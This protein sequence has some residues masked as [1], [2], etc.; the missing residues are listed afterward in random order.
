VRFRE[1][2]YL[3]GF[4][5]NGVFWLYETAFDGSTYVAAQLV[6]KHV[7]SIDSSTEW[8]TN[9]R[10]ACAGEECAL[11]PRLFHAD[12][13]P[14]GDFGTPIDD[15]SFRSQWPRYYEI[16]WE[17]PEARLADLYLIDGRFRVACFVKTLLHC[18]PDALIMI[19]DFANRPQYHVVRKVARE[20]AS[21][22]SLSVFLRK[23]DKNVEHL[24][25][26][27]DAYRFDPE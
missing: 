1:G 17:A 5:L 26:I 15:P 2:A 22:E 14:I 27:L 7:T 12:I 10:Q 23:Q 3:S 25:A 19:H 13:G 18:G 16:I 8:L 20:V 24:S 6:K 21:F 9:V 11:K 4:Q